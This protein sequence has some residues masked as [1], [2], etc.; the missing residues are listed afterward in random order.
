MSKIKAIRDALFGQQEPQTTNDKVSNTNSTQQGEETPN[1]TLHNMKIPLPRMFVHYEQSSDRRPEQNNE[2]PKV[3]PSEARQTR[4]KTQKDVISDLHEQIHELERL[5]KVDR[6][7]FEKEE[8]DSIYDKVLGMLETEKIADRKA[9]FVKFKNQ[10]H[11]REEELGEQRRE[12]EAANTKLKGKLRQQEKIIRQAQEATFRMGEQAS[13]TPEPDSVIGDEL[14]RLE[15]LIRDFSKTYAIEVVKGNPLYRMLRGKVPREDDILTNSGWDALAATRRAKSAPWLVMSAWLNMFIC[16][17][18]LGAPFHFM[19]EVLAPIAGQRMQIA[20]VCLRD[21]FHSLDCGK[22]LDDQ[23]QNCNVE[24]TNS[25]SAWKG[26]QR[27]QY[28]SL[29]T[30]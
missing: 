2:T 17:E 22:F 23:T 29:R 28:H 9:D 16:D 13:W 20:D 14:K 18:I 3:E 8:R 30:A 6:E 27:G 19:G 24:I 11:E 5:R 25:I 1:Q 26:L 15:T 21:L 10:W 7:K 12:L 4:L